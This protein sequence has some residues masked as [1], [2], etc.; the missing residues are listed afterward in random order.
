M[1][2]SGA[3]EFVVLLVVGFVGVALIAHHYSESEKL[4]RQLRSAPLLTLATLSENATARVVGKAFAQSADGPVLHGPITGRPCL[5]YIVTVEQLVS[6]GK[7]TS[8]RQIIHESKAV[9]FMLTDATGKALVMPTAAKTVLEFDGETKSGTFDPAEPAEAAFL[10]RHEQTSTGWL[11]NKSLRYREAVIDV[12]ETIAVLGM[13]VREPDPEGTPE[14]GY[15][16]APPTR[17][18]FTSSAKYPL[19]I[20]DDPTTTRPAR[21]QLGPGGRR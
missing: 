6:N 1:R 13:G 19:V 11:F 3:M 20:S 21:A 2:Q 5:M 18:R 16:S 7:T 10:A 15:R 9:P 8:W 17:I 14:D 12:G 4:K